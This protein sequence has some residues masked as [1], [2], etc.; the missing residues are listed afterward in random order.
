[1]PNQ[2]HRIRIDLT[3]EQQSQLKRLAGRDVEVLEFSVDELEQR[4]APGKVSFG[5]FT[6]TNPID[7]ST[8]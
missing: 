8:P 5:D 6:F 2:D 7:K 3:P 1:M 4:I